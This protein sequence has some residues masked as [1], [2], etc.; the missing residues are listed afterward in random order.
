[1]S[2]QFGIN[3]QYELYAIMKHLLEQLNQGI[4]EAWE[5]ISNDLV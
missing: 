2:N 3:L 1:M 4:L 5:S